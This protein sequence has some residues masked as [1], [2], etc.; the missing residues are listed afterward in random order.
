MKDSHGEYMRMALEEACN[1]MKQG[2]QP[3]GAV[4]VREG[5]VIAKAYS[6]KMG[7]FDATA[8]AEICA[9]GLATRTLKRRDLSDCIF[10]SVCEPCP[11]CGGAMINAHISTLVL[12]A[13]IPALLASLSSEAFDSNY[14]IENLITLT[15]SDM[16]LVTGVLEDECAALYRS[17]RAGQTSR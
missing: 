4:V 7:T 11:M 1:G 3:F 13:R 10:Y 15:G 2:V 8:H 5:T 17:L 9:V 14:T 6:Q 16:K 12:G